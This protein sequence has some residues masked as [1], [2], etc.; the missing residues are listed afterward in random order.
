MKY[1]LNGIIIFGNDN[2]KFYPKISLIMGINF[3]HVHVSASLFFCKWAENN[4]RLYGDSGSGKCL[5][6]M[7][8]LTTEIIKNFLKKITHYFSSEIWDFSIN[9]P[10]AQIP[11]YPRKSFFKFPPKICSEL[12]SIYFPN[13]KLNFSISI[14]ECQ[15]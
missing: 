9:F 2:R 8:T 4:F 3:F 11:F 12:H 13:P 10:R 6:V 14:I 15:I 1:L 7:I 5:S